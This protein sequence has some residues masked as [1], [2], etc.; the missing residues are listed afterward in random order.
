MDGHA[1]HLVGRGDAQD[2]KDAPILGIKQI[3]RAGGGICCPQ[4]AVIGPGDAVD[5]QTGGAKPVDL[6]PRFWVH[7][8]DHLGRGRRHIELAIAPL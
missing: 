4:Q 5:A 7:N 3:D 8:V 1:M 6:G 2:I